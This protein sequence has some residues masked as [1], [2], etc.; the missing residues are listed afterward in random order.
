M[1]KI[2]ILTDAVEKMTDLPNA[3]HLNRI[4]FLDHTN[5]QNVFAVGDDGSEEMLFA[6][7][8]GYELHITL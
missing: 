1:A 3:E 6:E 4:N 8:D 7:G 5:W 2:S